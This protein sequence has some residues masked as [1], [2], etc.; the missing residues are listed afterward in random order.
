MRIAIVIHSLG[1]GG[2]ERAAVLLAEGLTEKQHQ[3]SF[4]TLFGEE[5]DFYDLPEEI[6]RIAL[7][8][9]GSSAN[10]LQGLQNNL[11]RLRSLRQA[12]DS[13]QPNIVISFLDKTNVLTLIS[14]LGSKYPLIVSE[15]NDPTQNDI[16]RIWNLLRRLTYPFATMVVSCS[17]G[18]DRNW[19]WLSPKQR[20][21]IYNP[22]AVKD[23]DSTVAP[24]QLDSN[25]HK[26][27]AMGRLT[28]QK[29]FDLLLQAFALISEQFPNWQLVI[30]GEGE[31]RELLEALARKLGLE[32]QVIM[33]GLV[34]NP[35]P[36]LQQCELFV[37]SSRYE[38]FGNVIIEAMSCGI[39]VI[40][41]NCP[42]GPGEIINSGK[43]GILV[44]NQDKDRLAQAMKT[45]MSDPER[46]QELSAQAQ[47]SLRRF[48]LNEIVSQW[49]QLF[50]K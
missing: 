44:P 46:R 18:V 4:I 5:A 15:Q 26:V 20:A 28:P 40:S 31:Q 42:S 17:Q 16:G 29:G 38:G 10:L 9:D 13:C 3:V 49:E 21:V 1:G 22:L 34:S 36:V 43:N 25:F 35:F 47:N 48:E 32:S 6:P 11:R 19:S 41:T 12:V 50:N 33:P 14:C 45:L 37:L 39:P 24:L 8:V 27:V 23:R 2:A 7:K 30:L